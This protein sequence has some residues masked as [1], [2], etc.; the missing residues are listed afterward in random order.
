MDRTSDITI[1]RLAALGGVSV[2]AIRYYERRGLLPTP[3]R[4]PSGYRLYSEAAIQRLKFIHRA[5]ALGFSLAEIEQLLSLR[6]RPGTTCADIRHE[7]Q[8]KIAAVDRKLTELR[9][10]RRALAKLAD[11][12]RGKGPTSDCPILEALDGARKT[13]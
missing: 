4:T 8:E 3:A 1:G 13:R 9:R 2:Q 6:I 12:C 7:A 10:I 11:S 5:Q